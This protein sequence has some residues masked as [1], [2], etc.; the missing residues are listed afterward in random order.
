MHLDSAK[1]IAFSDPQEQFHIERYKKISE[2]IKPED[3]VLDI[4][5]GGGWG[6]YFLATHTRAKKIIL[7]DIA[8]EEI[9]SA[10]K[11]FPAANLEYEVGNVLELPFPD[12][13]FDVVCAC[14]LIEHLEEAKQESMLA[15]ICRVLKPGGRVAVS[16]PDKHRSIM[17]MVGIRY[18]DYGHK[19]ELSLEKLKVLVGQYFSVDGVYGQDIGRKMF[20]RHV[21]KRVLRCMGRTFDYGKV[22]FLSH[23]MAPD[24]KASYIMVFGVKA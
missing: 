16:T 18:Y 11:N 14:E 4:G 7:V 13:H 15:E 23:P 10:R 20:M 9:A 17:H 5:G 3:L 24:E 12:D 22:D 6:S 8:P 19:N 21:Q 2:F 1:H